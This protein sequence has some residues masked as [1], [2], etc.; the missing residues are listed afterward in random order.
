MLAMVY[1]AQPRIPETREIMHILKGIF[2]QEGSSGTHFDHGQFEIKPS[3]FMPRPNKY[4]TMEKQ[5]P[6]CY[7]FVLHVYQVMQ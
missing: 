1:D 7:N 3:L 4:S 5:V 6:G 2:A